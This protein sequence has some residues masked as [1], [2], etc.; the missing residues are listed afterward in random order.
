MHESTK[1]LYIQIYRKHAEVMNR[2]GKIASHLSREYIIF[3][4]QE[5][6]EHEEKIVIR[7]TTIYLALRTYN[8]IKKEE[9]SFIDE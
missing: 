2:L 7:R 6:L 4:T 9:M 5:A 3:L 8:R 1:R